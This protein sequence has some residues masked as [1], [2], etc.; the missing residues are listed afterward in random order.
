MKLKRQAI[1]KEILSQNRFE[2]NPD[3]GE[4]VQLKIGNKTLKEPRV[5]T[6]NI[7]KNGYR[8][9]SF[10]LNKYRHKFQF[11]Q[12]IAFYSWGNYPE[13][14][15]ID[16]INDNK[17]DNRICNLQLLTR[18][19]NFRKAVEVGLIRKGNY[20]RRKLDK[21]DEIKMLFLYDYGCHINAICKYFAIHKST[22]YRIINKYK[23]VAI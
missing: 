21:D 17:L 16:H 19:Q 7:D 9:T 13:Y 6:G 10:S 20:K 2:I 3:K 22:V 15:T 1:L 18:E 14:L 23:E 4:I 8:R 5:L 12:I 11:H